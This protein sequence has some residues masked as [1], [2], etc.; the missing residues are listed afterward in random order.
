MKLAE[1][2][3]AKDRAR[4]EVKSAKV[5]VGKGSLSS[6]VCRLSMYV[7]RIRNRDTAKIMHGKK[8]NRMIIAG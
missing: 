8:T 6:P 1:E 3:N 7:Q 2:A 5:G 4:S